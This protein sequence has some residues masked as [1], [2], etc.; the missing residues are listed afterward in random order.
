MSVS[1]CEIVLE[2]KSGVY[3]AGE[4]VRGTVRL[5]TSGDINTKG[6]RIIYKG[7]GYMQYTVHRRG[8]DGGSTTYTASYL[9]DNHHTTLWGNYFKTST[10]NKAGNEAIFGLN[11]GGG[12]IHIPCNN[13][14][15]LK[16]VLQVMNYDTLKGDEIL[17]ETT[18]NMIELLNSGAA[19]S[20]PLT[21]LGKPEK[22]ELT[23]SARI[24]PREASSLSARAPTVG[25]PGYDSVCELRVHKATGLR[26]AN[27]ITKNNVFVQ[28]YRA[29]E[30]MYERGKNLPSP[31]K[32][33]ILPAGVRQFPFAFPI[34]PDAPHSAELR[35][36]DWAF[37]RYTLEVEI[38]PAGNV[39]PSKLPAIVRAINVIAAYPKPPPELLHPITYDADKP[40]TVASGCCTWCCCC[41]VRCCP[42][43]FGNL[44]MNATLG[45]QVYAPGEVLD[46]R[47]SVKN[48]TSS[49]VVVN[50][51]LTCMVW[52]RQATGKGAMHSELKTRPDTLQEYT[53]D[54]NATWDYDGA[55]QGLR[56]PA[57]APSF[58]GVP[59]MGTANK[60]P[61]RYTYHI[62]FAVNTG[63]SSIPCGMSIPL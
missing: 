11:S 57:V 23:L 37:I 32:N 8:E 52:M 54:P 44:E 33:I 48:N 53:I 63:V 27:F 40:Q 13:D 35:V 28:A 38:E 16:V 6:G 22:G 26:N 56:V 47:G 36:G 34:R 55:A 24:V 14:E 60:D 10:R 7:R 4:V 39:S 42:C 12:L 30:G 3:F 61:V 17:G 51:V 29:L 43:M 46:L 9:Y 59:G 15:Q 25:P 2:R 49:R 31:D 50:V 5:Q 19:Q 18:V 58:Y 21:R 41:V 20:F 45:R 62:G 1:S